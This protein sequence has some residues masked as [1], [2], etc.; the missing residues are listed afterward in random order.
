[1]DAEKIHVGGCA[2]IDCERGLTKQHVVGCQCADCRF[3]RAD[4]SS[5]MDDA[6][7]SIGAIG[8]RIDKAADAYASAREA[9][10]KIAGVLTPRERAIAERWLRGLLSR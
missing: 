7:R 4:R 10:S 5:L 9:A 8:K 3:Q 2:C 1:M 6:R